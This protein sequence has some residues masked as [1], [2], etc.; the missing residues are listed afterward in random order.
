M[1]K[2]NLCPICH[3]NPVAV[4]Y[5]REGVRHYRNSC[6]ACIRINRKL[7]KEAPAWIKAGYKKKINCEICNFKFKLASQ[8]NVFYVDGNLKNNNWV[9]LKTVCLNCQQEL[10]KSRVSWKPGPIV[11]D[12]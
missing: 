10:Y 11:P 6:A 4:N 5:I 8:S 2:R 7:K 12:F 9:N 1:L 3:N